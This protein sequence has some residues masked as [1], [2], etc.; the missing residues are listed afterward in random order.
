MPQAG[1]NTLMDYQAEVRSPATVDLRTWG[2]AGFL[3]M[4]STRGLGFGSEGHGLKGERN[5][6]SGLFGGL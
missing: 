6:D 1:L 2:I 4:R 3:G 5:Q